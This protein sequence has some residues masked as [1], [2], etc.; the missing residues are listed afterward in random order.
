MNW[1]KQIW[2]AITEKCCMQQNNV[3]DSNLIGMSVCILDSPGY[4]LTQ[5][6][7][8]PFFK[9]IKPRKKPLFRDFSEALVGSAVKKALSS[10][11]NKHAVRQYFRKDFCNEDRIL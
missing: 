8:T 9:L 4:V 11:G 6:R 7:I 3:I 2:K 10:K 1:K 5:P